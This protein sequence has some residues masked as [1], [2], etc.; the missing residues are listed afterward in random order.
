[1]RP[2]A[3]Q[4]G[5]EDQVPRPEPRSIRLSLQEGE[6]LLEGEVLRGQVGLVGD[7]ATN[8]GDADLKYA[9]STGLTGC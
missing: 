5:P 2:E 3:G 7:N 9:R 8:Q 6:L 1:M 4:P